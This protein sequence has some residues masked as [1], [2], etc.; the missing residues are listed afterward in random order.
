[1]EQQG[2]EKVGGGGDEGRATGKSEKNY[3]DAL[4]MI[5]TWWNL[6][7]NALSCFS[8]VCYTFEENEARGLC[9]S[10]EFRCPLAH[11]SIH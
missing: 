9:V 4:G 1:M 10:V 6:L 8:L 11:L 2:S 3:T 5:Y 7:F